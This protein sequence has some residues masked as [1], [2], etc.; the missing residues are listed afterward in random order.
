MCGLGS[1]A[2]IAEILVNTTMEITKKGSQNYE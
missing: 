2:L 1:T